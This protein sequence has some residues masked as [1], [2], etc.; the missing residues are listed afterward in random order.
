MNEKNH[1]EIG[2]ALNHVLRPMLAAFVQKNLAQHFGANNWWQRGV[3]EELYPEQ[4][5]FLPASGTYEELTERLDVGLSALLID[6]HWRDIFSLKMPRN[7]FNWVKELKSIRNAW[8]HDSESFD[9]ATTI[10][11][12]DTMALISEQFDAETTE[13]LRTMWSSKLNRQP[14]PVE[15]VKPVQEPLPLTGNLK[16][17]RDVIEPHPD[18]AHGRYKQAEFAADLAQVVRGEGSSEYVNPVEFFSRTYLTTGLK[19]LLVET[20]RRLTS[21]NGEPVIQLKTSFG[22][23]KINQLLE[24]FTTYYYM[25]RLTDKS[26]LLETVRKGVAERTFA[27]SDD[28]DLTHELKFGD[29]SLREISTE[30]FLVKSSVAQEQLKIKSPDPPKKE[31]GDAGTDPSSPSTLSPPQP[32]LPKHFSMDVE[33]DKTRLNKSFNACIDEVASYLMHLPN[34]SVSI[35]LAIDISA[36]EGIPE[37]LK[38]VISENCHTLKVRNFYFE[39]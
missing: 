32:L 22:G 4:K 19:N 31:N 18:V 6:I 15:V 2:K 24:Y 34:V 7:A 1:S 13:Q 16:S 25:P 8:A 5:R 37:D 30:S 3:L 26:V 14:E 38:E 10:R 36:P 9:D 23:G 21:G 12:L 33:L 11:A 27:L 39:N 20:L 29:I 28:E 17:W 35:R